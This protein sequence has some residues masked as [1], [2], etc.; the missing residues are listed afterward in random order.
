MRRTIP[1]TMDGWQDGRETD[2]GR[3]LFALATKTAVRALFGADLPPAEARELHDA[4]DTFLTG[5]YRQSLLPGAGRLPAPG[6]RRYALALALACWRAH[7]T[8]LIEARRAHAASTSARS[9]AE[10]SGGHKD[11]LSHLLSVRTPEGAPVADHV[12]HDQATALVLAGSETTA[13]ALA[14]SCH[15]L[16]RHPGTEEELSAEARGVLRGRAATQ[17]D[18]PRL[19]LTTRVVTE[20]LRLYPPAWLIPRNTTRET[21]LAGLRLPAGSTVVFSPYVVHRRGDLYPGP[22][23]FLP[24]RRAADRAPGAPELRA[25]AR[26]A[27][28]VPVRAVSRRRRPGGPPGRRL[29]RRGTPS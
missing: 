24:G 20:A 15:L 11:V 9:A 19:P 18:L 3:E 2:L 1:E 12:I 4:L 23:R 29:T 14:W 10:P 6:N 27:A 25:C 8:R 5:I 17:D 28:D 22:A 16:S 21:E 13:A 26:A 7:T